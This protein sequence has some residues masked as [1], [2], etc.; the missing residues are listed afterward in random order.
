MSILLFCI[1]RFLH[2]T[3]R[4][5]QDKIQKP[6]HSRRALRN[7]LYIFTFI[8]I[9]TAIGYKFY[10]LKKDF[11]A[12][13]FGVIISRVRSVNTVTKIIPAKNDVIY[14]LHVKLLDSKT[15]KPVKN[16]QINISGK[17]GNSLNQTASTDSDGMA[18]FTLDKG[19]F[20]LSFISYN[21]PQEYNMPSPFFV[22]LKS[23]GTTIITV[24]LDA[25]EASK[26]K[27]GIVEVE[28][29]DKDNKPVP[30]LQLATQGLVLAPGY[31]NNIFSYTNSEGIAVF[32]VNEGA[33]KINFTGSKFPA[34]Y[35]IP[36]YIDASVVPDAVTRYTIRLVDVKADIKE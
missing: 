31:P 11:E 20:R 7:F 3:F 21:F 14:A 29:L 12:N 25:S 8:I 26:Q 32:K 9:I 17:S 35:Q 22:D 4:V 10:T 5:E 2:Y 28:V 18:K 27:W 23:I 34:Q 33:C 16:T 13:D 30:N 1:P 36:P 6:H 15:N 19:T 24:N